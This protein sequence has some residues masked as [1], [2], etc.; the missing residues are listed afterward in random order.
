MRMHVEA[1]IKIKQVRAERE[2]VAALRKEK[3]QLRTKEEQLR[4]KELLLLQRQPGALSSCVPRV[5]AWLCTH[6]RCLPKSRVMDVVP[7]RRQAAVRRVC[8][9]SDC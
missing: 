5:H 7:S 6:M 9:S 1:E 3:E 8:V 4:T 2:E